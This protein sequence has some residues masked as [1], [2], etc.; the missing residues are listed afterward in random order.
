MNPKAK[1]ISYH[2]RNRY[3]G[4]RYCFALYQLPLSR[5][6]FVAGRHGMQSE[7]I[8]VY[9]TLRRACSTGAHATYLDGAQFIDQAC[10]HGKLFRVSYYPALVLDSDADWVVGEVYQLTSREQLTRLD[11]Y[12]E[13]TYPALPEQEYQRLQV[14]VKTAAGEHLSAWVYAYQHTVEDLELITSG[15]FLN[16]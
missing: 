6:F 11:V 2:R 15:D 7:L 12:E 3:S 16:P 10:I 5:E 13:C 14:D 8:F 9:G 1:S 4:R